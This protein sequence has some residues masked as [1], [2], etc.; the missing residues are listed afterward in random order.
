[1][2][3]SKDEVAMLWRCPYYAGVQ[4]IKVSILWCPY[5][6]CVHIMGLSMMGVAIL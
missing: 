5:Y 1:M 3:V 4:N 6:E 2:E